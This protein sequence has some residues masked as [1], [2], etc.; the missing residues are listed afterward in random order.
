MDKNLVSGPFRPVAAASRHIAHSPLCQKAVRSCKWPFQNTR[1]LEHRAKVT[2]AVGGAQGGT[3][4]G[5]GGFRRGARDEQLQPRACFSTV[6]PSLA[7]AIIK[8]I[9]REKNINVGIS[10]SFF[11]I[12]LF[13][14]R[15][16]SVLRQFKLN[17]SQP[18]LGVVW[19][20]KGTG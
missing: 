9:S 16:I 8:Q 19:K 7:L 11:P 4:W 13:F 17:K 6:L 3:G 10:K 12:F 1:Q 5:G 14:T 2:E 15:I 20:N 18:G